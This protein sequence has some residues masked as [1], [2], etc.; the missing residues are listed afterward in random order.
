MP[1]VVPPEDHW[2]RLWRKRAAHEVSWYQEDPTMSLRMIDAAGLPPEGH[3]IDVGSGAAVL[4]DDLLVR[5][6]ENLTAVDV[7]PAAFARAKAR[8]GARAQRVRWIVGD[9]TKVPLGGP[10]DLWHDRAVFHFLVEE[11]DRAAYRSALDAHLKRGGHVVLATFALD[12]PER[13]SGL[14]ARRY[15]AAGLAAQLGPGYELQE[16]T[17]ESHLTPAGVVQSFQWA[18]FRRR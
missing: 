1:D 12:G 10:F 15:D 14:P 9:A 16:Q 2:D 4:I 11:A 7:A 13:C 5:G 8:L 18:R 6:F 17:R 3:V